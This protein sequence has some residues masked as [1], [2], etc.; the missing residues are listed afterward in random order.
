MMLDVVETSV[1]VGMKG[2]LPRSPA[3]E[4]VEVRLPRR[5]DSCYTDHKSVQ[6]ANG[7]QVLCPGRV[8]SDWLTACRR[9]E[10]HLFGPLLRQLRMR[11]SCRM[12]M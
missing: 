3:R 12:S 5:P 8:G 6:E 4:K 1:F 10:A 2:L 7:R 11:S 9:Q